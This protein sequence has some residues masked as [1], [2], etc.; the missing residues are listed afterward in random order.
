MLINLVIEHYDWTVFIKWENKIQ[1]WLNMF[2]QDNF[3]SK[4]WG[5]FNKKLI[6]MYKCAIIQIILK[7]TQL[8]EKCHFLHQQSM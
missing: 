5:Y 1:S 2:I 4:A 6:W 7:E 3:V 8:K